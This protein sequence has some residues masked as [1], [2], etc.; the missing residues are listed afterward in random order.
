MGN[1]VRVQAQS[2]ITKSIKDGETVQG[3]PAFGDAN[4]NKSY[5]YFKRLPQLVD[6]IDQL[7]KEIQ[8]LKDKDEYKAKDN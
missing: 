6:K 2:G 1:N 3:T 8:A 4:F 7:Q 5:I